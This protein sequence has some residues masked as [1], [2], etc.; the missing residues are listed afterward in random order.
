VGRANQFNSDGGIFHV[1]HRC[2]NRAFLLKFARDRDAYR[3][4]L[5]E[6]LQEFEVWMLDYCVTSN[7]VHLFCSNHLAL[8]HTKPARTG[9]QCP[10]PPSLVSRLSITDV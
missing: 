1:T 7:H 4:M 2:H 8:R 3:A 10:W 6:Q 5:R 9:R